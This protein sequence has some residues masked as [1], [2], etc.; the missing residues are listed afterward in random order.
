[1]ALEATKDVAVRILMTVIAVA[2]AFIPLWLFLAVRTFASP[3]G[4]WQNLA[5]GVVGIFFLG[6]V[7]LFAI[8]FLLMFLAQAV[9][10]G[11]I[12]RSRVQIRTRY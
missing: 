11:P 5:L 7:Q 1:M 8:I 4:F 2:V 6:G 12:R 10:A 3:E 9:W